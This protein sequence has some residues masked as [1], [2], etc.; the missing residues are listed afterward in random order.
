MS[1]LLHLHSIPLPHLLV[2]VLQ[3]GQLCLRCVVRLLPCLWLR[4]MHTRHVML[5][6]HTML[7]LMLLLL[8]LLVVVVVLLLLLLQLRMPQLHLL[9]HVR[10]K[11]LLLYFHLADLELVLLQHRLQLVCLVAQHLWRQHIW[12][13]I[14]LPRS[15][16]LHIGR[17]VRQGPDVIQPCLCLLL[18][19]MNPA[20]AKCSTSF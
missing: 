11:P 7:V 19:D 14:H 4:C 17:H 16:L 2:P 6:I 15:D 5:R 9:L 3:L 10:V 1:L 12:I 13:K 18:Q 8:L 20:S